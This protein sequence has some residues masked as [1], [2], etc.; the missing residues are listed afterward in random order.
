MLEPD[1]LDTSHSATLHE[2][3]QH[4]ERLGV[5]LSGLTS[6]NRAQTKRPAMEVL[7]WEIKRREGSPGKGLMSYI[8]L[9][10]HTSGVLGC[11]RVAQGRRGFGY[12]END[13]ISEAA[14]PPRTRG[15]FPVWSTAG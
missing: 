4:R 5:D 7:G 15:I 13:C 1:I 11:D 2:G 9:P 6:D 3:Q 8:S 14:H 10:S 12:G